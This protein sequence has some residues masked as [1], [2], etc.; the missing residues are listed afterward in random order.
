MNVDHEISLLIEE[1][2]RLGSP[3]DHLLPQQLRQVH[4]QLHPS[5]MHHSVVQ[6]VL[7][8]R[9]EEAGKCNSEHHTNLRPPLSTPPVPPAVSERQPTY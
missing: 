6:E 1:I 2:R 5:W 4:Q 9:L 8:S 7:C 3:D